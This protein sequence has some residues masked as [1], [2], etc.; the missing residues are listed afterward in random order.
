VAGRYAGLAG[1]VFGR[2]LPARRARGKSAPPLSDDA[3]ETLAL[4]HEEA[5]RFNHNFV[6]TEHLLLGLLRQKDGMA[7]AVLLRLRVRLAQVRKAVEFI[8]GH[9][10][11]A[12]LGELGLTPRGKM[13][14]ELAV[15]EA[16]RLRHVE[17]RSEHLLLGLVREGEGIAAGVL[18]SL[19]LNPERV[20]A[21]VLEEIRIEEPRTPSAGAERGDAVADRFDKFSE[22]AR[23]VLTLAQEE[24]QR[25]NHN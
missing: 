2:V 19:G 21:A 13:V 9:R 17:V 15:D 12:M 20:R 8:I 5:R 22:R 7:T 3:R 4:A 23:H 1:R 10:D 11:R 14:I 16:R 24:A 6:G 25:F 18:K